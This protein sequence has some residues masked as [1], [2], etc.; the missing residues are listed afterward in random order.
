MT[1]KKT[2]GLHWLVNRLIISYLPVAAR[3]E[4]FFV[5]NVPPDL[6]FEADDERVATVLGGMLSSMASQ[7]KDSCILISARLY[8]DGILVT[9]RDN[10]LYNT[11]AIT[12]SLQQMQGLTK[13]IGGFLGISNE[14]KDETVITFSFPSLALS[15]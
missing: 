5:N 11:M 8:H 4:S 2:T 1:E 7:S 6:R 9:V 3:N 10:Q 15:A 14:R 13:Q 12:H